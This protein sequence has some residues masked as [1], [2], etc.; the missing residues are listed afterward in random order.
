MRRAEGV[1]R[2]GLAMRRKLLGSESLP[3]ANSLSLLGICLAHQNKLA[4]AE[5]RFRESL[6]IRRELLGSEHTNVV[7][8]V[9]RLVRLLLVE[10]KFA[11]AESLS[12]DCLVVCGKFHSDDWLRFYTEILLGGSLLGQKKYADAE[13]LLLSGCEGMKQREQEIP[14]EYK[15]RL[16]EALQRV[17]EFYEAS[18]QAGKA[19]EW[20]A[21]L[22]AAQAT[23][24]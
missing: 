6:Q 21:R 10:K 5:A 8:S 12:R 20:K 1:F 22:H 9:Q 13:P 23:N 3:V 24:D 11:E 18:A 2:D 17:V 16:V 14:A 7:M 19:V 15:P 4:E